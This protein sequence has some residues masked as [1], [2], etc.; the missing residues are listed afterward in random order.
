MALM[1]KPTTYAHGFHTAPMNVTPTAIAIT[2]GQCDS[3]GCSWRLSGTAS[4]AVVMST[5][6]LS[7]ARPVATG[8]SPPSSHSGARLVTT[9]SGWKFHAG[10]G[11]LVAHSR[12]DAPHGSSPATTPATELFATLTRNTATLATIVTAPIVAMRL[13][14]PHPISGR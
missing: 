10:G 11:E 2:S 12:P 5:S 9:G 8:I 1:T 6:R 14:S 13:R 3:P 7:V 4:S